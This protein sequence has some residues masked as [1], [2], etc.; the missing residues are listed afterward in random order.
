MRVPF[1]DLQLINNRLRGPLNDAIQKVLSSGSYVLGEHLEAFER[2]WAQYCDSEYAVGVGNG[3]DALE[4]ALLAVGVQPGDEVLVPSHTFFATWLSVYNCGAI[5]IPIEPCADTFLLD[6]ASILKAISPRTKAIVP[7][8]LYGQAVDLDPILAIARS[9]SLK[10]VEDAAQAHGSIYDY[11]KI[12]SHGDAVAWSFYPGKNLGAI[13]DAGAVTTN[14]F[15]VMQRIRELRNYGSATKYHH[16]HLGKNS[17]LDPLQA[18]ILSVK[19]KHLDDWNSRRQKIAEAYLND[20]A[21]D[22]IALPAVRNFS[23]HVFHLFVVK[24]AFRSQLIE[25]LKMHHIETLIHYPIP[26]HKQK[27]AIRIQKG[28]ILPIASKLASQVLSLP[29]GPHITDEQLQHVVK[30]VNSFTP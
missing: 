7:V 23:S 15:Q 21:N 11:R 2:Q 8:H 28:L 3:L 9:Y 19:L 6:S 26:P 24:T 17:R 16:D 4:L 14:N 12:G 20:I 13:G 1:L 30:M 18:A 29:I 25:H 10:V 5:P 22:H 27:A